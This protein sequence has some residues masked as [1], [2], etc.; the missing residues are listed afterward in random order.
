[1][2]AT[3]VSLALMQ[4]TL[5]VNSGRHQ[6]NR[7]AVISFV[8]RR[9]QKRKRGVCFHR[10]PGVYRWWRGGGARRDPRRQPPSACRIREKSDSSGLT[11]L[12]SGK[13]FGMDSGKSERERQG[14]WRALVPYAELLQLFPR[15]VFEHVNH[16]VDASGTHL[17]H[18]LLR[19]I[20]RGRRTGCVGKIVAFPGHV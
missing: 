3:A 2:V 20:P 17:A 18:D 8:I 11:V 12:R 6:E 5:N 14:R 10:R 15:D 9:F 19:V 13:R 16:H 7:R 4:A 1:M